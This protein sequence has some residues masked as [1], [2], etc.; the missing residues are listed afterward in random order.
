[1]EKYDITYSEI[2]EYL[3][4]LPQKKSEN[5]DAYN[6]ARA[7]IYL[8]AYNKRINP[9]DLLQI[10]LDIKSLNLLSFAYR[11]GA[12]NKY[13]NISKIC[14]TC[15]PDINIHIID[16]INKYW[17]DD[18]KTKKIALLLTKMY[19]PSTDKLYILNKVFSNN[20][21]IP[22]ISSI[23][24]QILPDEDDIIQAIIYMD[25]SE[26]IM[27][28]LNIGYLNLIIEVFAL[29]IVKKL[30]I[31]GEIT[32]SPLELSFKNYNAFAYEK[33][34]ANFMPS[35]M[36]IN[37][38]INWLIVNNNI[39]FQILQDQVYKMLILSIDNG[40]LLNTY[41]YTMIQ[42]NFSHDKI[43][44]INDNL[45]WKSTCL[46]EDR[47]LTPEIYSM[48]SNLGIDITKDK[49]YI[50]NNLDNYSKLNENDLKNKLIEKEKL[51][52]SSATY[53]PSSLEIP[54]CS[55]SNFDFSSDSF[56]YRDGNDRWCMDKIN[57]YNAFITGK[58]P[59]NNKPLSIEVYKNLENYI[60]STNNSISYQDTIESLKSSPKFLDN[61][62]N[63]EY[64]Y[65][66]LSNKYGKNTLFPDPNIALQKLGYTANDINNL[67]YGLTDEHKKYLAMVLVN[68]KLS[69]P[70][71]AENYFSNSS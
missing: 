39:K 13:I 45:S 8:L 46:S 53:D 19:Y 55:N 2:I 66:L 32:F 38:I 64:K 54:R 29:K 63:Q 34:L 30:N 33:F 20:D 42:N 41:Q 44:E 36:L 35:Q 17:I 4:T 11:F 5:I 27:K 49:S 16:Y 65:K 12:T 6:R 28:S 26:T 57:A 69:N 51:K 62:S 52:F 24:A 25:N 22:D 70:L 1:M 61:L 18:E 3:K 10:A 68:S 71:F 37:S 47:K 9:N 48:A 58:N 7:I 21:N 23:S 59:F 15:D 67:F 40:Y 60:K 43:Q 56:Y 31:K 14:P 50:C